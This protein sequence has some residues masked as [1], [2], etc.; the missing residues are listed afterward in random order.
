MK[1]PEVNLI[2]SRIKSNPKGSSE[3]LKILKDEF[4]WVA[5]AVLNGFSG[6]LQEHEKADA[7]EAFLY[8]LHQSCLKFNTEK[9]TKFS[10]YLWNSVKFF[11]YNMIS[12]RSSKKEVPLESTIIDS[13]S[14][15]RDPINS[16]S[17]LDMLTAAIDLIKDPRKKELIKKRYFSEKNKQSWEEISKSFKTKKGRNAD[18]DTYS[19][20]YC[21]RL[22]REALKELKFLIKVQNIMDAN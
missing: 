8:I 16:D 6:Q 15:G 4:S 20:Q 10:S 22:H 1:D 21:M 18:R 2:I 13:V 7:S 14:D 5:K 19:V 3:D 9:G 17:R 11:C 12:C